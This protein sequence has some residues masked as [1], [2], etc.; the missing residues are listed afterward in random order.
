MYVCM[1]VCMYVFVYACMYIFIYRC[2][3][4]YMYTYIHVQRWDYR[5][6]FARVVF[7]HSQMFLCCRS[8][9]VVL[10]GTEGARHRGGSVS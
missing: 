5:D 4:V 1:H 8:D 2:M 6:L 7:R 10:S 3:C 9:A